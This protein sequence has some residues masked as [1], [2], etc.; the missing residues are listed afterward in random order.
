MDL[1]AYDV[2]SHHT[3]RLSD[4]ILI[5]FQEAC[6]RGE[7]ETAHALI[8]ILE[9]VCARSPANFRADRRRPE[10]GL[11]A[12]HERLWRG[13]PSNKTARRSINL[14]PGD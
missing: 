1:Q 14:N 2:S 4:K 12:A 3:R 11:V 13:G 7:W 9:G 5:A 10:E 8:K 6:D